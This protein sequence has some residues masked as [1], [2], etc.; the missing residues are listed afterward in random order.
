[1]S[2]VNGLWV[3]HD[4]AH[5][6]QTYAQILSKLEKDY[7]GVPGHELQ[8]IHVKWRSLGRASRHPGF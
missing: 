4:R 7:K 1:M 6:E 8:R 5:V 3:V 2:L